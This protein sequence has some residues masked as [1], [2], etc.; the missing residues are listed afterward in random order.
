MGNFNRGRGGGFSSRGHSNYGHNDRGGRSGFSRGGDRQMYKAVCSNCGK[1][2]EVP[3]RPTGSKPVYCSDC[4]EK[5]GDRRER[6]P[7]RPSFNSSRDSNN[8]RQEFET[9]NN[10][11]DKLLSLLEPKPQ[12]VPAPVAVEEVVEEKVKAP[13]VK[14]TASKKKKS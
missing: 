7:D 10:K 14:K 4:F 9:I 11:L 8:N 3:F 6:R 13:K 2:C 1:E 5:M 12:E